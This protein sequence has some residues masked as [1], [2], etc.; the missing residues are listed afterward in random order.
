[1]IAKVVMFLAILV[2]FCFV[3]YILFTKESL[4]KA[5][6]KFII[7][8]YPFIGIDLMPSVLSFNIFDLITLT[9]F[10]SFYVRPKAIINIRSPY[11]YVWLI[12]LIVISL[13]IFY[14]E[15]ITRDTITSMLQLLTIYLFV[16][17]LYRELISDP[18]LKK[19]ILSGVKYLLLFSFVF[20]FLQYIIG[21]SFSF[22]KSE[23]I[24]VAGGVAIRYPS[25]FQDPQKYAQF[26]AALSFVVLINISDSQRNEMLFSRIL[27]FIAICALLLTG[28]RAGLGGW[29]FGL[30]LLI[31][32]GNAVYRTQL[33]LVL[34]A[35][36]LFAFFY[37]EN[38]P[39][40]K[41]ADLQDSYVFRQLIWMDALQIHQSHPWLGIG[42]GNYANYV[43]IHHPDQYWVHNNEITFF[44]HPESGY[45]KLL[46][47]FGLIGF[48]IF[49]LFLL[50]PLYQA[51]IAYKN[52]KQIEHILYIA[53]IVSWM[54]G[55]YTVYSFGDIR[56]KVLIALIL[57]L[58]VSTSQKAKIILNNSPN[59]HV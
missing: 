3:A 41:R 26:L 50:L 32:F 13:G 19:E 53:A 24:N 2:V 4:N 22:A 36:G 43:S 33:V 6:I 5:Y 25:F 18:S 40:F 52:S 27:A 16:T 42:I 55:F 21:P 34:V 10:I 37:Q 14:S 38:L 51:Y 17:I 7:F 59:K 54:I 29:L 8:A 39:I 48:F 57:V 30:I 1:M 46:V 20:L 11:S 12:Y 23:N 58:T 15:E 45:L 56:I 49:S 47:E 31:G 35:I 44:D 9:Y 28:G